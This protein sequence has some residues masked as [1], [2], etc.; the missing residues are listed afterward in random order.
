MIICRWRWFGKSLWVATACG[1]FVLGAT[2]SS[3]LAQTAVEPEAELAGVMAS[4]EPGERPYSQIDRDI[5]AFIARVAQAATAKDRN[6]AIQDIC[7]ILEEVKRDPRLSTSETLQGYQS[8]LVSRL[9]Q[10]KRTLEGE[11]EREARLAEREAR[12]V[13]AQQRLQARDAA[14]ANGLE[15]SP[16]LQLAWHQT[17]TEDSTEIAEAMAAQFPYL[18]SSAGGGNSIVLRAGGHYGGGAVA[19]NASD[20]IELIQR[21]IKPEH[22]DVNGG[23]GTIFFYQPLNALVI[24]AS[25]EVHSTVGRS[26]DELRRAGGR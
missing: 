18:S 16:G 17:E 23:P 20:L 1:A 11:V 5:D 4:L 2:A 12:R 9:N 26:L 22:W 19:S 10:L 14:R 24:R 25:T 21:T 13:E 6:A 7:A 3:A 15:Q 8:K